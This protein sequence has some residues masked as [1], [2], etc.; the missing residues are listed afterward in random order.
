MRS[1]FARGRGRREVLS[2]REMLPRQA[3]NN[4][5][6]SVTIQLGRERNRLDASRSLLQAAWHGATVLA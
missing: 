1:L 2:L 4:L 6:V 5:E 3:I